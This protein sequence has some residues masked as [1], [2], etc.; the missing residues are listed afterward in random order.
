MISAAVRCRP[1]AGSR[2]VPGPYCASHAAAN[3]VRPAHS[4]SS[5][6]ST[7]GPAA[8]R[9]GRG[10]EHLGRGRAPSSARRARR[11]RGPRTSSSSSRLTPARQ[12]DESGGVTSRSSRTTNTFEPVPSQR[13][14]ARCWRRCASPA[15]LL[16]GVGQRDHVLRVGRRLH[17]GQRAALVAGPRHDDHVGRLG[18]QRRPGGPAHDQTRRVLGAA[19]GAERARPPVTVMRRKPVAAVI[20]GD[21]RGARRRSSS[22]DRGRSSPSA[23]TD[24]PRRVEVAVER[25][26]L[27]R[28]SSL[29][30]S[31]TPSPT[32]SAVVV[33][34]D[35]RLV[36]GDAARRRSRP[37]GAH[38]TASSTGEPTGRT[39]WRRRAGGRPSARSP[40]TRRRASESQVIAATGA[41]AERRRPRSRRCGSRR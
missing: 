23:S 31:K 7:P 28:R 39:R 15:P 37:S 3:R 29:I 33:E 17:A 14:A 8:P 40:P 18:A 5:T 41:E 16:A 2:S 26:R 11:H 35:D 22:S 4:A 6:P 21:H 25:E 20:G 34:R 36:A 38:R 13:F 32:V 30:V 12:P 10:E 27:V 24:R 19:G 9:A 1:I